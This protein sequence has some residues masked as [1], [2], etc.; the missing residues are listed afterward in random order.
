MTYGPVAPAANCKAIFAH[1]NAAFS[2][3]AQITATSEEAGAP[4]SYLLS[5]NTAEPWRSTSAAETDLWLSMSDGSSFAVSIVGLL[6]N[7]SAKATRM[8]ARL[9]SA[10]LD[11]AIDGAAKPDYDSGPQR[12]W[13]PWQVSDEG[14]SVL[15][16]GEFMWGGAP[17]QEVLQARPRHWLHPLMADG[18][19][20][21]TLTCK[22]VRITITGTATLDYWEAAALWAGSAYLPSRNLNLADFVRGWEDLSASVRGING[23]RQVLDRGRLRRLGLMFS[24]QSRSTIDNKV[25]SWAATVGSSA[26]MLA[27]P[28]PGRP[29]TWWT[30]AGMYGLEQLNGSRREPTY[31]DLWEAGVS[32]LEWR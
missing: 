15:P 16:W 22:A 14:G 4:A 29:A 28:E 7:Q 31:D 21:R 30:D 20:L 27:I 9:Y 8:R 11:E 12:A 25:E 13:A 26:P 24:G 10:P 1:P 18:L 2:A 5:D 32:L 19:T 17:P 3:L 23:R 6:F